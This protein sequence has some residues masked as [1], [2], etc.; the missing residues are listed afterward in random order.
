MTAFYRFAAVLRCPAGPP[1]CR[2]PRATARAAL[3]VSVSQVCLLCR[4][5]HLPTYTVIRT[6]PALTTRCIA[7]TSEPGTDRPLQPHHPFP[8]LGRVCPPER[9]LAHHLGLPCP[10]PP[11]R[12][13]N[14]LSSDLSVRR[15]VATPVGTAVVLEVGGRVDRSAEARSRQLPVHIRGVLRGFGAKRDGALAVRRTVGAINVPSVRTGLKPR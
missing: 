14:C 5:Q 1:A 8:R 11:K 3:Q 10:R 7:A 2:S 12:R 15:N 9:I 6:L 4:S 13:I